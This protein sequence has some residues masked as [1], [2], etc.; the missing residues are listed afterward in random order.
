ML[1]HGE[2]GRR[3]AKWNKPVPKRQILP[4]T[5]AVSSP[6]ESSSWGHSS[7]VGARDWGV[8]TGEFVCKGGQLYEM[9]SSGGGRW[10][11]TAVWRYLRDSHKW[12]RWQSVLWVFSLK[13]TNWKGIHSGCLTLGMAYCRPWALQQSVVSPQHGFSPGRTL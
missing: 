7:L 4:D 2:P 12:F 3:Y 13:L 11:F 6:E 10:W 9:K 5:T 8:G 1:Q